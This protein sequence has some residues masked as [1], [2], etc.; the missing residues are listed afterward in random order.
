MTLLETESNL[1]CGLLVNKVCLKVVHRP[2]ILEK[3]VHQIFE[4][5]NK[6]VNVYSDRRS[7]EM[8]EGRRVIILTTKM[9]EVVD[10]LRR[11]SIGTLETSGVV[12]IDQ[13]DHQVLPDVFFF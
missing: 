9:T 8:G 2:F 5:Y 1:V 6:I 12:L 11:F 10:F 4:T 3:E 7:A 13:D